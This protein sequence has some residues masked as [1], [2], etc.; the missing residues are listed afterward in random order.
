MKPAHP[1]A[2]W[3]GPPRLAAALWRLATDRQ[4]RAVKR[5]A[6]FG[7]RSVFQPFATTRAD[8]YPVVFAHL[9]E[10]L[11]AREG[12]RVLSFGCATGEEVFSLR[13]YLP[14]ATIRGID[15]N[16]ASIAAAQARLAAAP[17]PALSFAVGDGAAGEPAERYDAILCMAV[18]RDGRLGRRP[19]HCDHRIRFESFE[20][21]L[22][23]LDRALKPGGLLVIRHANFRFA[24]TA[25]A[26]RFEP[27]LP[28][29][30]LAR[31]PLYGPDNRLIA[32]AS[33]D[34]GI[35]RKRGVPTDTAP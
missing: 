10:A 1:R 6:W 7:G 26:A 2:G 20:R 34:D 27:A 16:R 21:T 23:D 29:T 5:L 3:R 14:R 13:A 32:D 19:P 28:L 33:P 30:S 22:A 9:R 24:D 25:L 18:L 4:Y 35:Y 15:I 31:I 8:R 12:V 17:D 11:G